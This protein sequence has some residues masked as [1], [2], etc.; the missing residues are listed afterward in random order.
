MIEYLS[1][2]LTL[3]NFSFYLL[4]CRVAV[5]G[6][7][8][9][10]NVMVNNSVSA[11]LLGAANGLAMSLSSLGRFVFILWAGGCMVRGVL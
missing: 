9:T 11:D 5:A 8:L 10:L 6:A 7:F 2:T 3:K 1:D 4:L